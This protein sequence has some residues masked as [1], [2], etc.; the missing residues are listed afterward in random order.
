MLH[1]LLAHNSPSGT[2]P[3]QRGGEAGCE[4]EDEALLFFPLMDSVPPALPCLNTQQGNGG[5][6][7]LRAVSIKRRKLIM[8]KLR[9]ELE[10][11]KQV[12]SGGWARKIIPQEMESLLPHS[13]PQLLD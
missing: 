13:V 5:T 10:R 3:G 8:A 2:E 9:A 6:C 12:V 11:R 1:N 4:M 7:S